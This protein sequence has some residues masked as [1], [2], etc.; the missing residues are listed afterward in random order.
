MKKLY[1]LNIT[2]I[3]LFFCTFL[4]SNAQ[5]YPISGT[6]A[7]LTPSSLTWSS[8]YTTSALNLT[9]V[10]KDIGSTPGEIFARIRL[11]RVGIEI[12]NPQSFVATKGIKVNFGAPL[13]ITGI[14]LV[15]NFNP[16]HLEALGVPESLF[17]QGGVWSNGFWTIE[18]IFYELES[19]TGS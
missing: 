18:L 12:A 3:V 7:F 4:K 6:G 1:S 11:T 10:S 8:L 16:Q 13:Q 15:E 9:L 5:N 14:D 19:Q 17:T 2:L